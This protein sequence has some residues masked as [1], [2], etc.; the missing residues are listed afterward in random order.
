V[1]EISAEDIRAYLARWLNTIRQDVKLIPQAAAAAQRAVDL[2]TGE[3]VADDEDQDE[4]AG[5]LAA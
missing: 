1:A 2:I 4:T 3:A 5:Q